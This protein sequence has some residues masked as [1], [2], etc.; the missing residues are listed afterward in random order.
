MAAPT[1]SHSE[2][3][4]EFPLFDWYA[5]NILGVS[6]TPIGERDEQ[7]INESYHQDR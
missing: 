1:S 4:G 3:P 2:K 5:K 7:G 6:D